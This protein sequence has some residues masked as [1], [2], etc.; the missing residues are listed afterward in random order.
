MCKMEE[1]YFIFVGI[2]KP[3]PPSM[4][5]RSASQVRGPTIPSVFNP[6]CL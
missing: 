5:G 2:I 1:L 6:F 4:Y 3:N